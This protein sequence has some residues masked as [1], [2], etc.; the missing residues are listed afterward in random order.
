M[1]REFLARLVDAEVRRLTAA[2]KQAR[3]DRNQAARAAV[4]WHGVALRHEARSAMERTD[5]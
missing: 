2:L 3:A 5:Q 1:V 4:R